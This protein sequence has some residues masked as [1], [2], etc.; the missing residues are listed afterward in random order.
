MEHYIPVVLS[1]AGATIG[2]EISRAHQVGVRSA[3]AF[4]TV[5]TTRDIPAIWYREVACQGRQR[6]VRDDPHRSNEVIPV[7]QTLEQLVDDLQLSIALHAR[8]EVF[9]H[10]GV[11]A[12]NGQAIVLPGRSRA[13]KSTLVE[14]LVRAGATYCS[15]E[16]A[17][18]T[19]DGAVAP[20]ARPLHLR[21]ESGRRVIEP[22][23]IG[24]VADESFP[25]GL[26]LFTRYVRAATFEPE[27]VPPAVAALK[28]FDNTIVAEVQ[29]DRASRAA[30]HLART[31]I[32]MRSDRSDADRASEQILDLVD[33]T[34][35]PL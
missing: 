22:H 12:W 17:C 6:F 32:V 18:V 5:T 30:A 34:K 23:T 4:T 29:P 25:P 1:I 7:G 20:F 16:Y 31:A 8:N 15:D 21:T 9:V 13:G 10:A 33:R 3:F 27:I 14:A 24:S 2:F 26:V 19:A 35:V 28:I 11:V